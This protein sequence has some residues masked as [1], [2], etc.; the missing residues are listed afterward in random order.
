MGATGVS[1]EDLERAPTLAPGGDPS[2]LDLTPAEGFLLS[3]ID[4]CTSWR[5]LRE[6]GGLTTDEVDRCLRSWRER[7]LVIWAGDDRGAESSAGEAGLDLDVDESLLD[8]GL[9]LDLAVQRR[10]LVFEGGLERSYHE[11]LGIDQSA[12]AREIK[13][14]YFRLSKEF[15]PDR[16]FRR[17]VGDYGARLDRIF[18]KILEAY[19]LLSDPVARAEI[20][21]S[22]KFAPIPVAAPCEAS[23]EPV[24]DAG[25]P[26]E[27]PV[28]R[29]SRPLRPL[30]RLER[31]RRRTRLRMPESVMAER[32]HKAG[33]FFEAAR[34][35][36]EQGRLREAASSIRLAIAFDPTRSEYKERFA[37]IQ[38]RLAEARVAELL[39]RGD[40]DPTE[41]REAL[42]LCEETLLYRPH[43]PELN[44]RAARLALDLDEL[45]KAGEYAQRSLEHSPEVG[46]YHRVRGQV[47]RAQGDKGHAIN[48]LEKAVQLDAA[49]HE[50]RRLL[51]LFGRRSSR[52]ALQGG[53]G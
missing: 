1:D 26:P 36:G 40:V 47:Y 29:K 16:Y 24:R 2:A 20:E 6:I 5:L 22:M 30:S 39:E 27:R 51:A 42:R 45:Q 13:R 41:R 10:I 35:S 44:H 46:R 7:G 34:V 14:S 43:D 18:K 49:D 23:P 32:R 28:P 3:R 19:E 8:P 31:L 4:G 37:E 33:V 17:Q 11:L 48:E 50:A 53:M 25:S 38:T 9:D 15:H 21:K 12:D 52:S